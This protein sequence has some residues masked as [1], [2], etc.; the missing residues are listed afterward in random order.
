M[1]NPHHRFPRLLQ[2]IAA[3]ALTL[4]V[5]AAD[6]T[7]DRMDQL[8]RQWL[9]TERQTSRLQSDWA[10]QKPVL[11]QR[12]SLL[13]AEQAQLQSLLKNN[14]QS[15]DEVDQKRNELLQKQARLEDEQAQTAA[16]VSALQSRLDALLPMLPP[17][18]QD[19]WQNADTGNNAANNAGTS[20]ESDVLRLQLARLTRLK[21][22]NERITLHSMRLTNDAGDEVLV[23][24]IYLGLAQAWFASSNGEFRG[25]GRAENGQ[26]VWHFDNDLSATDVLDAIAI[27]EKQKPAANVSLPLHALTATGERP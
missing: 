9:D 1:N 24:Q 20:N 23:K 25:T 8:T 26:W 4:P 12:L 3:V 11:E 21:E 7:A 27:A 19:G 15:R 17:P 6:L 13:K 14:H 22:F 2:A 16:A 5:Q 18:L 10:Q